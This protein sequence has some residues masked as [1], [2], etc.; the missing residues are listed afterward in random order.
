MGRVAALDQPSPSPSPSPYLLDQPCPPPNLLTEPRPLPFQVVAQTLPG[1]VPESKLGRAGTVCARCYGL[2]N[3]G[4]VDPALTA[5][6]ATHA[7]VSPEAFKDMLRPIGA[8]QSTV[9][10]WLRSIRPQCVAPMGVVLT[11]YSCE[12]TR[13]STSVWLG[14][15]AG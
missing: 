4:K 13:V 2:Q 8:P 9:R 7:E 11:I 6:R 5:Q 3:Y 12:Y 15:V 1:Y 10:V 14:C